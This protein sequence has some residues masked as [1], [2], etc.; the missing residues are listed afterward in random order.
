MRGGVGVS[1]VCANPRP[2]EHHEMGW[3]RLIPGEVP[4]PKKFGK[5]VPASVKPFVFGKE[6]DRDSCAPQATE[7]KRTLEELLPRPLQTRAA[8]KW[9]L[10]M[11]VDLPTWIQP[12]FSIV[13]YSSQ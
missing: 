1:S 10:S 7:R 13:S 11:I 2:P 9:M 6:K 4:E 8:E 12:S 3:A 5:K